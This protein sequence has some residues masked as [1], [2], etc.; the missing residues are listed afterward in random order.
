M[1]RHI[2]FPAALISLLACSLAPSTVLAQ[3]LST[4]D[5]AAAAKLREAGLQSPVAYDMLDS[6]C[7]EVG[8]RPA[9]SEGD[10][11]AVA[12]A[13][14]KLKAL[15]F[16]V[17]RVEEV[18]LK[19]WKRGPA[20]AR[21]TAPV[22]Q[23]LVMTALGGSVST[24][25]G[26]IDA[27]IAYYPTFEALKADTS[28]RA[29][30]RIVYIDQRIERF[31]DGHGYGPGSAVRSRGP[32]EAARHGAVAFALRSVG[33]DN[34]RL[35][36]TGATDYA[37]GVPRIPA[38]AL[39]TPDA[40]VLARLQHQKQPLRMHLELQAEGDIPAVSANVIAEI[41]GTDLKNE[42]VM[43]GGH[44]DSWDL[45][46]GAIDDGAG[47]AI[48]SGAAKLILDAGLKPRRTIR[49]VLFANEE[50]GLDGALAYHD[51]YKDQ[52]HQMVGE[53]D[54]GAG[55]VFQIRSRV[56][57]EALP[58]IQQIAAELAPL[59]V[60]AGDNAGGVGADAGVGMR[61]SGWAGVGLSQDASL[62]FDIHHTA[63][64]TLDKVDPAQL[65]QNV[66]AWAVTAWLAAQSPEAFGPIVLPARPAGTD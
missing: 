63:N 16:P 7:T 56:R 60:A 3:G 44:L 15:G 24:P 9:G 65:R 58:V 51:K 19:A 54:S 39:S 41:P 10:R 35:A 53:S 12:W 18:P 43:I 1:L 2:R 11:R 66:A 36:H 38:L 5:L 37:A 22:A 46:Q 20:S 33:T 40:D 17:V 62:Y 34:N 52:W 42:V 48:V 4:A 29:R 8:P 26:G 6:L 49:V 13:A 30:G 50:H 57:P 28:D 55:S 31:K 25:Q 47:V 23:E 27:E 45:G 61:R 59:G 21:L 14:A 32:S 64:D